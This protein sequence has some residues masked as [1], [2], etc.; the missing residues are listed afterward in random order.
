[1]EQFEVLGKV[2]EFTGADGFLK[3]L[4]TNLQGENRVMMSLC[5]KDKNVVKECLLSTDLSKKF[6]AK[7]VSSS[8]L[9]FMEVSYDKVNKRNYIIQPRGKEEFIAVSEL[10][11]E[12]LVMPEV[13]LEELIAF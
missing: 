5:D 4:T 8:N 1:M 12:A 6:R 9:L 13:N 10:K 3:V 11:G 2:N 7:T